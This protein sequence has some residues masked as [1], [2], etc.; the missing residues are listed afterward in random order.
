MKNIS[1][2]SR[3]KLNLLYILFIAVSLAITIFSWLSWNNKTLKKSNE[4]TFDLRHYHIDSC[5]FNGSYVKI[6]GW[7][8]TA[9]EPSAIN[10]VFAESKTGEIIEVMTTVQ[11]RPDV[12]KFFN[13]VDKYDRSGFVA[14][15]MFLNPANFTGVILVTSEDYKGVVHA[16]K[17][18]CK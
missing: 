6:V 12:S 4:I 18:P 9:D 17:H 10:R 16:A 8:F 1:V 11:R 3:N 13:E 2:T 5:V 7:A 15:K 14:S